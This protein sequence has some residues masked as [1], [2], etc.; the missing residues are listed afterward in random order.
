[1][2]NKKIN[3]LI[4]IAGRAQRFIDQ[5]YEMPKPLI[6]V[7]DRLMIDLAMSSLNWKDCNLIFIV[8]K[9][10]VYSFSIDTVL[11]NIFGNDIKVVETEGITRGTLCTCLL[12]RE[13]IDDNPLVIYTP[14]VYFEN[15]F[16]PY[17][18][19]EDTDGLL[20]T[21]KANSPS[22]SYVQID[23]K[24]NAVKTAEK[25]VISQNAAVGV[26]Y[27]KNGSKFV[28]YGDKMVEDEITTNGEFYLCPIYN[29]FIKNGSLI[30]IKEVEKM[31]VLG[32]PEEL[33]FYV[34]NVR[35]KLIDKKISL[36][37][38]HSGFEAKEQFKKVLNELNIGF[39]DHGCYV[40]KSCDYSD[41]VSLAVKSIHDSHS[42]FAF[43]FCRTG[44]G[45]NIAAN[46]SPKIISAVVF[47]EY[48]AKYSR[49]HNCANF[50]SIPSK[51]VD[52]NKMKDILTSI[53]SESFDGGRH[54][55]RLKKSKIDA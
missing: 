1:M 26:Y 3:L 47:D 30:K 2:S 43:G 23:G 17:S 35:P 7:V 13:Y 22:H 46:K 18:I 44:Q 31:H 52:K 51:Y 11:R 36:C 21:F 38:D 29:F 40:D 39:T 48:T 50:F 4:P 34:E 45:I 19:D 49:K 41:F 12:A 32:T 5:G 14:D 28:E 54:M 27:F 24:G 9:D 37:S 53:M 8:R 25:V 15:T 6:M 20:L 33:E 42:D 55:T 16:D 10:H